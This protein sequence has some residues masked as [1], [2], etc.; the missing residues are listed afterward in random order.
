MFCKYSIKDTQPDNFGWNKL[1]CTITNEMCPYQYRCDKISNWRNNDNLDKRCT[2]YKH[3]GD[4]EYMTQGQY[5]VL[6]EKRGLLYVELDYDTSIT[7][8]NPYGTEVPKGVD[9][10]KIKDAYYVKGFEPKREVKST[11]STVSIKKE[12][13]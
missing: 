1:Y 11:E 8:S 6:Y 4:K 13:K 9:L 5:K 7:V 12:S 2:V 10:I 3:E